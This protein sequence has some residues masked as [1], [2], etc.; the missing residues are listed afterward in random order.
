[1][2][3]SSSWLSSTTRRSPRARGTR[4]CRAPARAARATSRNRSASI[5][6]SVRKSQ[7]P[8][9]TSRAGRRSAAQRVPERAREHRLAA[10]PGS[11]ESEARRAGGVDGS[12]EGRELAGATFEAARRGREVEDGQGALT[13][14]HRRGGLQMGRS[15]PRCRHVP[16]ARRPP[17]PRGAAGAPRSSLDVPFRQQGHEPRQVL[18]EGLRV[19]PVE[20][21]DP[22][23][24]ASTTEERRRDEQRQHLSQE[25]E[26]VRSMVPGRVPRRVP[27]RV[28]V[29]D[30]A[31][32]AVADDGAAA[33]GG[34][35][36]LSHESAS[37]AVEG[38]VDTAGEHGAKTL[39][40][41][42]AA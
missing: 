26:G 11:D 22:V 32:E 33:A 4:G 36:R 14:G 39:V 37:E 24:P 7:A 5:S 12:D 25:R 17:V 1:M 18:P 31:R 34:A 35:H 13:L 2:A 10:A 19:A 38:G 16:A 8:T 21:R 23:E 6:A 20:E 15:F 29:A 27:G 42:R 40:D 41:R 28:G 3:R 30:R 9:G